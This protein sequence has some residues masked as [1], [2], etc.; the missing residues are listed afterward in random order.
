MGWQSCSFLVTPKE[1]QTALEPFKL[2]INN[3]CVPI[4]YIDTPVEEFLENYSALY[5]RLINDGVFDGALLKQIAFTS[6]LSDIKFCMEHELETHI[7]KI[8]N[9][10]SVPDIP[11]WR[12]AI[13]YLVMR[14]F[15]L[16]SVKAMW[17]IMGLQAKEN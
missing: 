15:S 14:L 4:D 13:L 17:I 8:I 9:Y 10:M 11:I 16:N 1:L 6:N 2:I 12:T 7:R 5:E 3:T